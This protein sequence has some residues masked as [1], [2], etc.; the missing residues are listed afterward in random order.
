M[1]DGVDAR[2]NGR[3]DSTGTMGMRG[4]ADTPL[5]CLVGGKGD[6]TRDVTLLEKPVFVMKDGETVKAPE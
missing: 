3:T 1:F 6:P 5:L 4:G 2:R